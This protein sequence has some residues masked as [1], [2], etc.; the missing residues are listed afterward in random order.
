MNGSPK[1]QFESFIVAPFIKT[2]EGKVLAGGKYLIGFKNS[3]KTYVAQ[4]VIVQVGGEISISV[5]IIEWCRILYGDNFMDTI[6]GVFGG[7]VEFMNRKEI[8]MNAECNV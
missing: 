3:E 8:L 1:E 2:T 6:N 7:A 4:D 5:S